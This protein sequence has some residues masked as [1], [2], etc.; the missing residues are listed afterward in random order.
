[1]LLEVKDITVHYGKSTALDGV[2]LSVPEGG[3]VGIVGANGSGKS[4]ILKAISGLVPLT[5]GEIWFDGHRIDGMKTLEIVKLG[6]VHVPEGRWLFPHLSVFVNLQLGATLRRDKEGIESDLEK[7]FT[8][9]PRLRERRNQKAGTLSGGEQEMLAIGR[10]LMAKPRLLMMDEPSLGLA[11]M[12]VR[13]VGE[14][15]KEINQ[16]GVSV[17]LVEQNVPLAMSTATVGYALR[18]GQV[19]VQGDMETMQLSET[20]KKAYMGG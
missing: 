11:P 16:T 2:T 17:L 4:T 12:M 15:I 3:V 10:G 18:T 5:A 13:N 14:V 1:M 9:F 8:R 6:V 7:V 20:V 19:V